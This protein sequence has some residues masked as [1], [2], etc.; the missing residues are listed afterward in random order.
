MTG[1]T[2]FKI[3]MYLPKLEIIESSIS[4]VFTDDWF[5]KLFWSLNLLY[6]PGLPILEV[7]IKCDVSIKGWS[8]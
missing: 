7:G 1:K 8:I 4:N 5:G 3:S 2:F 6:Q